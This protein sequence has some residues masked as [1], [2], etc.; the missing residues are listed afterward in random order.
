MKYLTLAVVMTALTATTAG[1]K[2]VIQPKGYLFG[3]IAN[4][5][6]SVVYF[7]DIQE[8]DSICIDSKKKF[9]LGRNDYA[10]QLRNY[11]AEQL[12]MPHRTCIVSFGLTRKDAEKKLLKMRKLYTEKNAG[13]YEIHNLNEN[14]FKFTTVKVELEE[15]VTSA[16]AAKKKQKGKKA[17]KQSKKKLPN[18]KKIKKEQRPLRPI[19][20]NIPPAEV[21]MN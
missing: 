6:D 7:T 16:P 2:N 4:F 12:K 8:I 20:P 19:D 10:N 3:F 18:T 15:Q 9:L 11:F 21:E 17:D 5:T 13:S 1:A 14:E